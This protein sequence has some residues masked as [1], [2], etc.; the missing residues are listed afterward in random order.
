MQESNG[1]W[2]YIQIVVT[3][4]VEQMK[5]QCCNTHDL[6]RYVVG[7]KVT[8]VTTEQVASLLGASEY[9]SPT[10]RICA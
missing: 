3:T 8:Q 6:L 5:V 7:S 1:V 2:E 9:S 10:E 4:R